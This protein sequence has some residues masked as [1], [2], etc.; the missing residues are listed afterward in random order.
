MNFCRNCGY[1]FH[2][3]VGYQPQQDNQQQG[4]YHQQPQYHPAQGYGQQGHQQYMP[5]PP[6]KNNT[7][8]YVIL[9]IL[10]LTIGPYILMF[11]ILVL[12][13]PY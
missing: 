11:L 12:F 8:L 13:N 5:Y 9:I 1:N 6:R 4:G 7:L 10:G 2:T 3:E